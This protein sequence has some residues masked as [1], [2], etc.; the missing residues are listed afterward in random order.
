MNYIG[1]FSLL[2]LVSTKSTLESQSD[3]PRHMAAALDLMYRH[4]AMDLA[5]G[6]GIIRISKFDDQ[7]QVLSLGGVHVSVLLTDG[8]KVRFDGE[9]VTPQLF[10]SGALQICATLSPFSSDHL[11]HDQEFQGSKEYCLE[12]DPNCSNESEDKK[13]G[14]IVVKL[15]DKQTVSSLRKVEEDGDGEEC[16]LIIRID[17]F[18]HHFDREGKF[19]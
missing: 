10:D 2:K 14:F 15:M 19:Q 1:C 18:V 16:A 13:I 8:V 5:P 11:R 9:N 6:V 3:I 17:H 7:C 4:G 12:P